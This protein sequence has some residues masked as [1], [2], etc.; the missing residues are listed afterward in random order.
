MDAVM[1]PEIS[2]PVAPQPEAFWIETLSRHHD[3]LSRQRCHAT[4]VR[5]GRSYDNDIVLDDPH[6]A[7]RHLRIR[8]DDGGL[9]VAED[10]GSRGGLYIDQAPEA[11]RVARIDGH[12]Q[13]RIGST[14]L[15]V[16]TADYDV[17]P[18]RPLLGDRGSWPLALGLIATVTGITTVDEWFGDIAEVQLSRYVIRALLL[19]AI[20][21]IWTTGW[22]LTSRIFSGAMHYGRHLAIA[23]GA[24][25]ALSAYSTL[26]HVGAYAFSI[27]GILHYTY[28]G[29]WLLFGVTC[30]L[31][32]L[33]ISRRHPAIKSIGVALVIGLAIAAESLSQGEMKRYN[34]LTSVVHQLEPPLLRLK[35]PSSEDR[36]FAAGDSLK[37]GLDRARSEEQPPAGGL[38]SFDSDNEE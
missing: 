35:S 16:R 18:E 6:V 36:F 22:A 38:D 21:G 17:G 31:H 4:E 23:F 8:R 7:A 10:L 14:L 1:Q 5:I 37:P 19:L 26:G 33:V 13:L 3:V 27:G 24:I 11:V 20:G 9:L 12:T 32:L 30:L 25:L 15:R 28:I 29:S 34:G 2:A